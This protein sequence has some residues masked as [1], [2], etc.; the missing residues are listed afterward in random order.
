MPWAI[1]GRSVGAFAM[2]PHGVVERMRDAKKR[3]CTVTDSF[4]AKLEEELEDV[5][6]KR[7]GFAFSESHRD[8]VPTFRYSAGSISADIDPC[9]RGNRQS[10]P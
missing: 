10:A 4:L 2:T 3:S 7:D 5:K 8:F 6:R 9:E 1:F